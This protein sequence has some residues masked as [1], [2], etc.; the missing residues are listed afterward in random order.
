MDV[1]PVD[2]DDLEEIVS[3]ILVGIDNVTDYANKA[4][5]PDAKLLVFASLLQTR[6]ILLVAERLRE[7]RDR[8]Q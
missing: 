1:Q 6:A 3:Q 2:D 7:L 8:P 5:F 4:T